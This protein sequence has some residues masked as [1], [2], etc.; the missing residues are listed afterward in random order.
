M[1]EGC[2]LVRRVDWINHEINNPQSTTIQQS[3]I[4]NHQWLCTNERPSHR[5]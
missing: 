5:E 1:I 4:I 3:K 2:G